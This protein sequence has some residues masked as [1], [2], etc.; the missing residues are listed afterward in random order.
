MAIP[1]PARCSLVNERLGEVHAGRGGGGRAGRPGVDRLIVVRIVWSAADVG[2]YRELADGREVRL[3][4]L[5]EDQPPSSTAR[6]LLISRPSPSRQTSRTPGRSPL[7]PTSASHVQNRSGGAAAPRPDPPLRCL[8]TFRRAGKTRVSLTTRISPA[9]RSSGRSL[10]TRCSTRR[11]SRSSTISRAAS[12]GSTGRSAILLRQAVV[13][14][15]GVHG[16]LQKAKEDVHREG[17]QQADR[18]HAGDRNQAGDVLPLEPDIARE[19][20]DGDPEA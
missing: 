7:P 5:V 18:N 10:N 3:H 15:G 13:E 20:A 9:H 17:Q 6:V 1:M 11:D 8:T 4:R 14:V 16:L 19:P 12:R 2:R